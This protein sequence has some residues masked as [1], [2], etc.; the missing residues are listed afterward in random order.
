MCA[1]GTYKD[2]PGNHKCSKCGRGSVSSRDG[3][4]CP[5]LTGSRES[6]G[7]A[8]SSDDCKTRKVLSLYYNLLCC[9]MSCNALL[10]CDVL[11]CTI[12]CCVMLCG[13]VPRN[14]MPRHAKFRGTAK[15]GSKKGQTIYKLII[16]LL[17]FI[18]I[19]FP[20]NL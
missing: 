7:K 6:I 4:I 14:A 3:T 2:S 12:I 5:C 15:G 8:T 18:Y 19:L 16:S 17:Q 11:C 9:A 20:L 10:Y 13:A 1:E